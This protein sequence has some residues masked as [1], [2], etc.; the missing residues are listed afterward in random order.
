MGWRQEERDALAARV[1]NVIDDVRFKAVFGAASRAEVSLAGRV[2]LPDG[3]P[4]A[5]FGQIDRLIVTPDEIT[6]VDFKT[7]I[8]PPER[9]EDSPPAYL[10]QLALYRAVLTALYPGKRIT[11]ALLWT[12]TPAIME[13]APSLLST[14]H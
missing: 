4:I 2:T 8:Q 11:C 3:S 14:R 6:I 10:R 5:V 1:M 7:N 9:A 13:I 12:E